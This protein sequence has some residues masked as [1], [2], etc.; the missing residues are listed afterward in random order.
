MSTLNP[1]VSVL[2]DPVGIVPALFASIVIGSAA[3][4]LAWRQRPEP[5]ATP[6]VAMLVGQSWWSICILFKLQAATVDEKTLWMQLG[7]IGVVTIPVAWVL[8]AFEYTGRDR[9]LRSR[10]VIS[11]C[12]IPA[13]TVLLAMTINY[14]DL[15]YI[16]ALGVGPNGVMRFEQGGTWYWVIAGYTYLLGMVGGVPLIRLLA[17]DAGAFRGQSAAL[18]VALVVPWLTNGLFLAGML[19]TSGLDPTPVAFSVSGFLYLN[20]ITRFRLLGT[21]PAPNRRAREILFDRMQEG[22]VV[23]DRNDYVV[24]LN[25]GCIRMLGVDPA[26]VLGEPASEVIPGYDRLPEDG[27][28]DEHL[29]VGDDG[30]GHPYDV[31]VTGVRDV[32]DRTIGRVITFHDVAKHLRQQQRLE[33]LN[34]L[35]RHNIRTETNLIYGYADQFEDGEG[36]E[37]VK[38]RALRIEEIARKGREAIE[39][40]ETKSGERDSLS[41]TT[42]LER[43][44][45]D[46]REAHPEVAITFDRPDED[47]TVAGM[48]APVFTN[49]IENAAEHHEGEDPN[50]WVD[51]RRVDRHAIV[52]ITDDGPGIDEYELDVLDRGT[53]TSLRHGSGMGLWIIKWGME[54]IGGSVRFASRDPI[55]TVVTLEVPIRSERRE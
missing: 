9:Y 16:R 47:T 2:L 25:E 4:I 21:S 53:E 17:S 40:F 45:A 7:W 5:G 31:A 36:A 15:M 34:R 24:D 3:A 46:V 42:L 18:L 54:M 52:E 39:L 10:Y 27:M 51:A 37:M 50:V 13:G 8:F 23:V 12:L 28:L 38:Q 30:G 19:P 44:I 29:T 26:E 41:L 48:L 32:R 14:H 11:L 33:V 22:A 55:G 20:A 49:A 43:T 1:I 35:L 6:L